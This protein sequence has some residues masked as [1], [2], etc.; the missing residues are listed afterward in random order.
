MSA[1]LVG[2]AG[3]STDQQDLTAQHDALLGLGVEAERIC[4]DHGPTG[5]NHVRSR[6]RASWAV[7]RGTSTQGGLPLVAKGEGYRR[8]RLRIAVDNEASQRV[9][10]AAGFVRTNV[11]QLRRE[12]KGFVLDMVTWDSAT[13]D[14]SPSTHRPMSADRGMSGRWWC[15]AGYVAD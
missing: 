14:S 15:E 13:S 9:A 5:T 10:D 3:C 4:V 12:R 2:Y 11:P 8:A 7:P 6:R 1:L